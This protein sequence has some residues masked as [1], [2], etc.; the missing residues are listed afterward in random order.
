[1]CGGRRRASMLAS[2][3][4]SYDGHNLRICVK[5]E[6]TLLLAAYG[7]LGEFYPEGHRQKKV[8]ILDW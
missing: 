4:P 8:S 1:M 7:R 5:C 2:S 6:T 3:K